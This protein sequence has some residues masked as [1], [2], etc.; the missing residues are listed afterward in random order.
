MRLVL[1]K[2]RDIDKKLKRD[3]QALREQ[4]PIELLA[5]VSA[6]G[7]KYAM[8]RTEAGDKRVTEGDR[9]GPWMIVRIEE[10]EV[11]LEGSSQS[12]ILRLK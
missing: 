9:V 4:S 3:E 10:Q 8:L 11:T 6:G 1:S 5:I 2:L 12:R 7:F